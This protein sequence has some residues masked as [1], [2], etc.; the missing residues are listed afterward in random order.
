[1]KYSFVLTYY[2]RPVQF[3]NSLLS[4]R[5]HY[6]DRSDYEIILGID[7]KNNKTDRRLVQEI[8]DQ[9]S[10]LKINPFI[11]D[12][13]D[14][15][16]DTNSVRILNACVK[17]SSGE[18]I[19][20][21]GPEMFHVT[22]ILSGLDKIFDKD[23]DE[24]VVCAC[25]I[26]SQKSVIVNSFNEFINNYQIIDWYQHS[27]KRNKQFTWCTALKKEIF[28]RIGGGDERYA[29]GIGYEDVSFILRARCAKLNIVSIDYLYV[30]H[31][32]H[33]TNSEYFGK[34][35]AAEKLRK[36]LIIYATE[37]NKAEEL[38]LCQCGKTYI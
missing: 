18:Y 6:H 12:A 14:A 22:N 33:E 24:Y 26:P 35:K 10:D 31:Q 4:Y 21:T 28:W 11:F 30:I 5:H 36:N 25:G 7:M 17:R 3:Y 32:L 27:I 9:F 1:M 29:R 19:I 16:T 15:E 13:T 20:I 34:E 2:K 8:L 38:G 37:H 23:P